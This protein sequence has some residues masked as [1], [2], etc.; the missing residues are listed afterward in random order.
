MREKGERIIN[1]AVNS[2]VKLLR[3]YYS[4]ALEDKL[5]WRKEVL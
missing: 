1:V 2:L 3:E 5:V 4:G